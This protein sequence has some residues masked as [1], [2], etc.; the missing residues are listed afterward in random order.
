MG[1]HPSPAGERPVAPEGWLSPAPKGCRAGSLRQPPG[2]RIPFVVQRGAA[3]S[4]GRS[5][6]GSPSSSHGAVLST[7]ADR[8]HQPASSRVPVFTPPLCHLPPRRSA[9][10]A[11]GTVPHAANAQLRAVE[12]RK[13]KVKLLFLGKKKRVKPV[14]P[15]PEK[16]MPRPRLICHILRREMEG[17]P[18]IMLVST[19]PSLLNHKLLLAAQTME[20]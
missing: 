16:T 17:I 14:S 18:V 19:Q 4:P 13:A 12:V 9:L 1:A 8:S 2:Y 6:G 7:P 15:K 3:R 5:R 20:M 11:H 10:Q